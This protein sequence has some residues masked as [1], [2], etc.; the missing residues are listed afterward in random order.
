M[1][2][3]LVVLFSAICSFAGAQTISVSGDILDDEGQPLSSAAAVLLNPADSTLL[4]FAISGSNGRFEMKNVRKGTYLM[5]VSLLGFNTRYQLL[6]LPLPTGSDIGHIIMVPKVFSIDEVK[7]SGERIPMRIKSDTIE[8]DARAYKVQPDAVAEDLVRKLPGIEVDRA[9]NIKALGEDV[10]N[11][12]V[13]GKEFFGNDPKVA[14]RN[15]PVDAID[16]VQLFDRPTDESR[17]TGIDDGER[18][19]TINF[20]LDED[21]KNGI[22]GDVTAGAGTN[23]RAEAGAK[24]YRFTQKSQIA[25]IGMYNNINQ[26]GFSLRDYINFSGGLSSFSSGDGHVVVGGENSFPVNFGQPV[27][28]TGSNGAAGFNLSVSNPDND[29]FFISYLGNGSRRKLSDFTTS[30]NYTPSGSFITESEN[31][32]TKTDTAHRV[33][34]GLRMQAGERQN[35]IVNGGLSYNSSSDPLTSVSDS[36]INDARVNNLQRWSD[37]VVSRL[38]GNTDGSY[39]LKVNEGKTILKLSGRA[40]WSGSE[41]NTR[42]NNRTEFFETPAV[43]INN[44]FY[45]I[46]METG[47]YSASLS[48][49]QKITRRS[50]ID[51]SAGGSFSTEN[52]QRKQGELGGELIPESALSPDFG[53][54]EKSLRPG[55]RWKFISNKTNLTIG[56]LSSLGEYNTVLNDDQ[57]VKKSYAFLTPAA[58]MEYNYRSG[59]RFML[60]YSTMVST[61]RAL[62]LLPVVNNLNPLSLIYGNRDLKP[63]YLHNA[64]VSWWL[65]DQFSFT[66]LL[67]SINMRYA[68]NRVGYS[69]TIDENLKQSIDLVNTRNDLSTGG[70]IDFSTAIK[71]LGLK[72]NLVVDEEFTRGFSYINS[73]E[74]I[75]TSLNQR[76]SFAIGNRNKEKWDVETGTA[77]TFINT[78][79]SLQKSLNDN[80]RD[81]SWFTEARYTPGKKFN[82][83]TSADITRY[84]AGSFSEARLVPLINAEANFYFLKNQRGVLTLAAVDVLNRNTGII[85]MSELNILT[86]RRSSVLGRYLMLSFKYRLNKMGDNTGGLDIQVKRR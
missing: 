42:F 21:K 2:I 22:F 76:V 27:Y 78:R 77:I 1:K 84:S 38:S 68:L 49:T 74:N 33:V 8:Y 29:R 7:I 70:M 18:N 54:S 73:A 58:S 28:G 82:M 52:V 41:S 64:R 50:F 39:L 48:L 46:G 5:Q 69:R 55:I 32:E 85:R 20:V 53:K 47:N 83:M 71:P 26:L 25:A 40:S 59:R 60:D 62:Q 16:K 65:F 4:Y 30:K 67:T 51:L 15:L 43:D 12:L 56:V 75:N 36:R 9:G 17:F 81:I 35:I 79:Y 72:V 44:Q 66:T 23:A 6:D 10:K 24:A 86:E 80:Y 37:E 13:D 45:D 14:T 3:L 34:A 57:G 19:P 61:P 63:E 31:R 11:V